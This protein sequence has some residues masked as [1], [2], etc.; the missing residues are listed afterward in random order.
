MTSNVEMTSNTMNLELE[1]IEYAEGHPRAG[2]VDTYMHDKL[3]LSEYRLGHPKHGVIIYS[4]NPT[5]SFLKECST[6]V[7]TVQKPT[8]MSNDERD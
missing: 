8:L 4:S 3:I 6:T 1:Y 7:K 5:S 2:I